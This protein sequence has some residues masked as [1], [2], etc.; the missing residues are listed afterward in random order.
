MRALVAED[1]VRLADLHAEP[2]TAASCRAVGYLPKPLDLDEFPSRVR[3]ACS[4]PLLL[5]RRI[6]PSGI[7]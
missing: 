7:A 1:C 6:R 4:P 3:A 5:H 2:L